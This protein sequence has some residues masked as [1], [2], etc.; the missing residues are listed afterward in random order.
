ME[1]RYS[2]ELVMLELAEINPVELV[3]VLLLLLDPPDFQW[4]KTSLAELVLLEPAE[5]KAAEL[6]FV[7]LLLPDPPEFR[8]NLFC[9]AFV[10]GSVGI[11]SV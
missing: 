8:L 6:V 3:F 10:P 9:S 5:N 7:F 2:A 4:K 1:M 11:P